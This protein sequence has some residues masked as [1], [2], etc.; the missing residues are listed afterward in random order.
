ME[1]L[2][3]CPFC[4]QHVAEL[5]DAKDCE[6]CSNFESEEVC[7]AY[8]EGDFCPYHFVVCSCYKGGCGAS[9][10]WKL[11][12]EEAIAAWNRRR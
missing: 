9:G 11:T 5:S 10:G 4:G 1:E 8:E 3:S 2:K 6:T 12:V 7:P